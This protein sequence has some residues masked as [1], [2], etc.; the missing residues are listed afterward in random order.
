MSM[1]DDLR[2]INVSMSW[3]EGDELVLSID[4]LQGHWTEA[5]YLSKPAF[6]NTGSL[7]PSLIRLR[8]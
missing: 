5:Q 2:Q 7:T 6:P 4:P 3:Q 8:Y 1:A